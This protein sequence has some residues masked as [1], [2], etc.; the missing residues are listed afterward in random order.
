MFL[1]PFLNIVDNPSSQITNSLLPSTSLILPLSPTKRL[2]III[3]PHPVPL[4]VAYASIKQDVNDIFE[5]QSFDY[6]LHVGVGLNG[7]YKLETIAWGHGYSRPDVDGLVPVGETPQDEATLKKW[8]FLK[9]WGGSLK[10][11]C[12]IM[13]EE[14]GGWLGTGLDVAWICKNVQK[15]RV[16]FVGERERKTGGVEEETM[17]EV[18]VDLGD[19]SDGETRHHRPSKPNPEEA[20]A[21]TENPQPQTSS[22]QKNKGYIIHPSTD[23]G[24]FLCEYIFR[25]SLERVIAIR[26]DPEARKP[27]DWRKSSSAATEPEPELE[28][29]NISKR[30]LFMH[31]PDVGHPYSIPDGVKA[32]EQVIVGMVLDGEGLRKKRKKTAD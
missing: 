3:R 25:K 26:N 2:K 23:A 16:R 14:V 32:L 24:R 13:Q 27:W 21:I 29:E 10:G 19:D 12:E 31:V 6:I 5:T 22:E 30:V 20:G 1:Q 8:E 7:G 18:A 15:G 28:A 4:R 17:I 11:G 9:R